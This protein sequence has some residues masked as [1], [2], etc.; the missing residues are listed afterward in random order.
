MSPRPLCV[1]ALALAACGDRPPAAWPGYAEAEYVYVASSVAGRLQRLDVAA[2]QQVTA[3]KVLFALDAEAERAAREEARARLAS[4][5]SQARNTDKGKRQTEVEVQLAQLRQA[6]SQV[7]L[8][9]KDFDRKQELVPTGAVSRADFDEARTALQ[10]AQAR[11]E[12]LSAAVQVARLPARVDE[13]AAAEAQVEAAR[14]QLRATE[15]REQ[16]MQQPAPVAGIVSDTFFRAGEFVNA[17]QPVLALL[18]PGQVKARFYVPQAELPQ[19]TLGQAVR[20]ACDG[21]GEPITARVSFIATQPEYT[22]PVIYSNAQR[23]KLV[24]LVEARPSA[25]DG[26]RLRPGQPLDVR[27]AP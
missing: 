12:E 5:T 6:R 1:V 18:P 21:C 22:P 16:Q 4:A 15:W 8:A 17:G 10:Q 27:K 2:G 23:S 19:V 14:Q 9:R 24:F 7:E 3:G 11:V 25:A 26:T 13:R 20:L